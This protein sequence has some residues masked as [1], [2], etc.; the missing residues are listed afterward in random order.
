M[1]ANLYF[2]TN[3]DVHTTTITCSRVRSFSST[4]KT[5]VTSNNGKSLVVFVLYAGTLTL[6]KTVVNKRCQYS[7]RLLVRHEFLTCPGLLVESHELVQVPDTDR[8]PLEYTVVED[9]AS[10]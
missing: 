10:N 9:E 4:T 5:A 6:Y 3:C 8:D 1:E 2:T 7:N